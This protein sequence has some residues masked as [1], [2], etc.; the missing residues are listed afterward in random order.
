[1]ITAQ[2]QL[3]SALRTNYYIESKPGSRQYDTNN[4]IYLE[5]N[6]TDNST[7]DCKLRE[8]QCIYPAGAFYNWTLPQLRKPAKNNPPPLFQVREN[9]HRIE[10]SELVYLIGVLVAG[11]FLCF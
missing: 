1:M 11:F 3:I 5:E 9:L 7:C 6:K 2:N 4:G 8:N 10:F